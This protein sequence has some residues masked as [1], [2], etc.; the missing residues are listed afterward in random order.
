LSQETVEKQQGFFSENSQRFS[1]GGRVKREDQGNGDNYFAWY[2]ALERWAIFGNGLNGK[3]HPSRRSYER[4]GID[5][6][7]EQERPKKMGNPA[8]NKMQRMRLKWLI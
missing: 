7:D 4:L 2:P 5:L 8:C 1:A 3:A 6:D